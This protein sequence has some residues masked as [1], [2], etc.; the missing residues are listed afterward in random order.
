MR[1][2]RVHETTMHPSAV[3][4]RISLAKNRLETPEAFLEGGRGGRDQLVG[5]VWQRYREHLARTR[6]LDFDDLLLE[7]VRLLQRAREGPRAL[8][9]SAT[10]T[11]WWTSTRTR[12]T[13]ST[14]SSAR[15]A[16]GTG[17][18]AWWATT[19]SRSTAGAGPT[20]ARSSASTRTSRAPRSSGSRRTTARRRPILEAANAVIRH[21]AS[22]HEKALESAKGEGEP[23]RCRARSRTRRPRRSSWSRRSASSC[24]AQEAQPRDFAILFRTQVQF[25][26]FEAELRANGIPYVVVGGMSFFD[27]KEVRDVVAFLKLAVQ[28]QGRDRRCCGS[29]NTP[30]RGVGKTSLDRVLAFATDH[31]I[32]AAEAFERADEIEKAEPR[33]GRGLPA[34][35]A[36]IDRSRTSPRRGTTSSP[37]SS[38]SSTPSATARRCGACTPTR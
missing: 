22:R 8:P 13:R 27:R 36:A 1:E 28:P 30:P 32:S 19:T 4:A 15:S 35:A 26:T 33:G 2:L 14:R 18:S 23:I 31:G 3:L 10:A 38:G 9:R 16:A 5:S 20:S 12:T 11:S 7:T 25:R 24:G 6:T 29:I 21:N 17:T 34:A 37:A